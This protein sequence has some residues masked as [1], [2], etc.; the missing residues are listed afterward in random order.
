MSEEHDVAKVIMAI[1]SVMECR[2]CPYPCEQKQDS[3]LYNCNHHW[4]EIL[5]S[6]D[7]PKNWVTVS[8][9]IFRY[10]NEEYMNGVQ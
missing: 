3:S 9:K 1:T 2:I 4:Y 5:M 10:R 8:D 7:I 6:V